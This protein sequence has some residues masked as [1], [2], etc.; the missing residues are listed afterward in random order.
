V[1]LDTHVDTADEGGTG[2]WDFYEMPEAVR[3]WAEADLAAHE[4]RILVALNHEPFHYEPA[5]EFDDPQ[6]ADDAGL[7]EKYTVRYSLAGHTHKNGFA[8]SESGTT[9]ITTGALSGMRWVLPPEIHACG[10]RLFYATGGELYSAWKE[11]GK[12]VLGFVTPADPENPSDHHPA[13]R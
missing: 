10:Y 2:E 11:T 8:E 4:G 3:R 9:H 13:S 6:I 7:F 5:W 12:R 1:A